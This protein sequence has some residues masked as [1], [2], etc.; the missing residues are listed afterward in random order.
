MTAVVVSIVRFVDDHQPGFVEFALVD[1]L[2]QTHLFMDKV[3][4]VTDQDLRADSTYPCAG[5]LACQVKAEFT[6]EAGRLL[7]RIDTEHPYHVDSTDGA[8][9]F[10]VLASQLVR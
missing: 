9:R 7:A 4:V 10:V 5:V 8:T 3:P 6:D 1:A 2:G